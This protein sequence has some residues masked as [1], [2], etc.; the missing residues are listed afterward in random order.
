M[1]QHSMDPTLLTLSSGEASSSA[2][3]FEREWLVTNGIGGFAAGTVSELNTRRYH[4]LLMAAFTPPLGRTLLV[5]KLDVTAY[6]LG[7]SY[8]LFCNEFK[9][10]AIPPYLSPPLTHL[11]IT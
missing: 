11:K 4:G 1:S 8:P 2:N 9:L 7:H 3:D 6:Y 10:I 5:S